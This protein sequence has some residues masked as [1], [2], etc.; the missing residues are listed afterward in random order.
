MQLV[1]LSNKALS[2][3]LVLLQ[4][5]QIANAYITVSFNTIP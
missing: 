1:N 5:V 2:L 4:R 3:E